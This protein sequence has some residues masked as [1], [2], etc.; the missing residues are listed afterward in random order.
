MIEEVKFFLVAA[1]IVG[2]LTFFVFSC[3]FVA[4][5]VDKWRKE[6]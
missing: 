3:C 5:L 2:I 1:G 4:W 6:R